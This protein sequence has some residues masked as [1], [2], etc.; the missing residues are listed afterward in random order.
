MK[1]HVAVGMLSVL[2]ALTLAGCKVEKTQE[3]DITLPK[4]EKTKEGDVTVPKY[5]VEPADV[6][7]GT[8][9][10][11]ITVP[12]VDVNMPPDN[13]APAATPAANQ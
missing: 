13:N 10:T 1:L 2:T 7:V 9:K 8:T 3:G 4:F 11:E 5:D 6:T 12:T